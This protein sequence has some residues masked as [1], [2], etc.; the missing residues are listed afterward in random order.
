RTVPLHR[1]A[2]WRVARPRACDNRSCDTVDR[3]PP[4]TI[5]IQAPTGSPSLE[6][7]NRPS[8]VDGPATE[9]DSRSRQHTGARPLE[10]GGSRELADDR[11]RIRARSSRTRPLESVN[12]M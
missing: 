9:S 8:A 11:Q 2:E 12:A 4:A 1:R 5:T 7:P 10:A 6:T 3:K